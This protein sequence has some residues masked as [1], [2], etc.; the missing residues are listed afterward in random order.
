MMEGSF[1]KWRP[2]LALALVMIWTWI[3]CGSQC[4]SKKKHTYCFSIWVLGYGQNVNWWS[5]HNITSLFFLSVIYIS[6]LLFLI[7][8]YISILH[9]L[10]VLKLTRMEVNIRSLRSIAKIIGMIFCISRVISMALLRGPKL[11]STELLP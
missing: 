3:S 10:K 11:S 4:K 9:V 2:I 1:Y 6:F 7:F 8:N 5:E